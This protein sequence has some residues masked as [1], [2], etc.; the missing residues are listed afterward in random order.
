VSESAETTIDDTGLD[1]TDFER[2]KA[3]YDAAIA[4]RGRDNGAPGLRPHDHAGYYGAF[5]L[6]SDG[7][8]VDA[9]HHGSA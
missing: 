1:V 5:V 6:D 7:H 3:F 8:D 9:V 4:A 2:S